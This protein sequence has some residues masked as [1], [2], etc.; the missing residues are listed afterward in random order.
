MRRCGAERSRSHWPSVTGADPI[1]SS[2]VPPA[3]SLDCK[4]AHIPPA[5]GEGARPSTRMG[6]LL[7]CVSTAMVVQK[8]KGNEGGTLRETKNAPRPATPT[9]LIAN[10]RRPQPPPRDEDQI[11]WAWSRRRG[12]VKA[13]A[14]SVSAFGGGHEEADTA[15]GAAA[16]VVG[17]EA[18]SSADA[19]RASWLNC[20]SEPT[21]TLRGAVESKCAAYE[22]DCHRS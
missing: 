18:E 20:A 13:P 9:M 11:A 22:A 21:E 7:G 15:N 17:V 8:G 12:E 10:V 1:V 4:L 2:S 3:M 16:D 6:N 5:G 19:A 14:T